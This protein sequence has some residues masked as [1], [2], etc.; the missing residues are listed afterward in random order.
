MVTW[1]TEEGGRGKRPLTGIKRMKQRLPYRQWELQPS[2][3]TRHTRRMTGSLV[4]PSRR[5]LRVGK[6]LIAVGFLP[7]HIP[8]ITLVPHFEI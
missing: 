1:R 3:P 6:V 8:R 5:L 2:S 4:R 7:H